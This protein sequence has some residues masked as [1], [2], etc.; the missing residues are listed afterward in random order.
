[1]GST[2]QAAPNRVIQ[3][4]NCR[5]PKPAEPPIPAVLRWALWTVLILSSFVSGTWCRWNIELFAFLWAI[6]LAPSV[7]CDFLRRR[8]LLY[9]FTM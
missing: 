1:M 3:C 7:H 6:I 9:R 2:A 5:W 4:S 8:R